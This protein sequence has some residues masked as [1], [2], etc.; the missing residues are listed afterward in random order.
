M[1]VRPGL[2]TWLENG[3]ALICPGRKP[4]APLAPPR[5]S[6]ISEPEPSSRPLQELKLPGPDEAMSPEVAIELMVR[7]EYGVIQDYLDRLLFERFSR[8]SL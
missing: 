2:P 7:G 3:R 4:Q 5:P 8:S 1:P 6:F